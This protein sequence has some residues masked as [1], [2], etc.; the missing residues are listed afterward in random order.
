MSFAASLCDHPDRMIAAVSRTWDGGAIR[1]TFRTLTPSIGPKPLRAYAFL[2]V[3][4]EDDE[5]EEML[6]LSTLAKE[7][8]R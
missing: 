8:P 5:P 3:A 4:G 1:E 7:G 6:N 2:E